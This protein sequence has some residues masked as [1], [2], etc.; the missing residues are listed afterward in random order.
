MGH[1]NSEFI[2]DK[3]RRLRA[4]RGVSQMAIRRLTGISERTM[5]RA[6]VAG[7]VTR[8]TAERLAPVL[9]V[10]VED[11]LPGSRP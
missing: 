6:E 1:T 8:R 7:V 9:G 11:L 10:A 5:N 2:G 3:L 4:E